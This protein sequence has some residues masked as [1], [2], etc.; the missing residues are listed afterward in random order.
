MAATRQNT[1]V[2]LFTLTGVAVLLFLIFIFGGGQTL[3]TKTY[4]I[5]VH[6]ERG[7][8]G[9]EAGQG[10]TLY[11]K[12]VGETKRV[13]FW[14]DPK[15]GEESAENGVV[16]ILAIEAE[17][18][19]PRSSRIVVASSIMGFGRPA[20]RL[21]IDDRT[22][23]PEVLPRDGTGEIKGRMVE[24]L[25]QVLPPRIQDTLSEATESLRDLARALTPVATH[26]ARLLE[27]R[28]VEKVDL[29]ELTANLDTVIQRFDTALRNFNTLIGDETNVANFNAILANA[30]TM[31][32]SG[33]VAMNNLAE[34]SRN[35]SETMKDTSALMRKLSANADE[36]SVVLKRMDQSLAL[37]NEGEGTAGLLLRDNRLYEELV[38]SAKRLTKALDDVRE[39]ADMWKRGQLQIKLR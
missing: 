39:I 8:V 34:L 30:K 18:D 38:L 10:V 33:I 25:D 22:F 29:A 27:P 11:G 12:R 31:S 7:V 17:Y 14:C 28:D 26:L 35:G 24:V 20:I 19:I 13:E 4:E 15:T 16:V 9:V 21:Q 3:F 37:M 36:L 5:R 23:D 6:F 2:G 32:D 1:I